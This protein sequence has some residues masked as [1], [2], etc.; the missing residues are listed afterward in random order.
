MKRA[1][2]AGGVRAHWAR[3]Q[4]CGLVWT[5]PVCSPAIRQGRALE[6]DRAARYWM[7][8]QRAADGGAW[9]IAPHGTGS[10]ALLT[11]T[12]H[13][14]YGEA[15]ADVLADLRAVW[16]RMLSGE[17]WRRL[18]ERYGLAHW[19][20]AYDVT[21][22]ERAQGGAG[23]HPHIHAVLFLDHCLTDDEVKGLEDALFSR[24]ARYMTAKGRPKLHREAAC[25]VE[26]ARSRRD[27][28]RYVCQVIGESDDEGTG[29]GLA[30]EAVRTDLKRSR[31]AGR[32]SPWEL[33]EDAVQPDALD[34]DAAAG[35]ARR[36]SARA[37][38]QEYEQGT[39]RAQAVR[40][41]RGLRPLV[42]LAEQAG[43]EAERAAD[44]EAVAVE[45]GGVVVY[46]CAGLAFRRGVI[47]DEW[48]A[49]CQTRGARAA[50][51]RI[52][53]DAAD[54]AAA[55]EAVAAYVAAVAD[56]WAARER[57]RQGQDVAELLPL[58]APPKR[59]RSTAAPAPEVVA[60]RALLAYVA[61]RPREGWAVSDDGPARARPGPADGGS[62][63]PPGG[64][65]APG[66]LAPPAAA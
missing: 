66:G 53:E 38:W 8:G 60:R 51:L 48:R 47:V 58:A 27:V 39:A 62:A 55:A 18:Q 63:P 24:W 19:V 4:L 37:L 11:L 26:R 33:L 15:L 10:V 45:R 30:Q 35:A 31:H 61:G 17:S 2:E 13:H 21:H 64:S 29:W 12:C 28:T 32:R 46:E 34:E 36:A 1:T 65:P 23:W 49:L 41:S 40:W 3:V 52:A 20:R 25:K 50:V 9:V 43:A 14:D 44:A 7:D 6:L 57:R 42:G 16:R 5:C 59:R 56:R 54:D 22:G